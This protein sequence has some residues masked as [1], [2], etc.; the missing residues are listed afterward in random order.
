MPWVRFLKDYDER[1]GPRAMKQRRKGTVRLLKEAAAK[2][3]I[4]AGAAVAA[5]RPKDEKA[6]KGG[7]T[8]RSVRA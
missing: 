1:L 4:K 5:E 2:D 8:Y 7:N 3:A 6:A